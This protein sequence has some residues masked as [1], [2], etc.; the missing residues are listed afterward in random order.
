MCNFFYLGTDEDS[1]D[2][3]TIKTHFPKYE[4]SKISPFFITQEEEERIKDIERKQR[5]IDEAA[6]TKQD[7]KSEGLGALMK[8]NINNIIPDFK[9]DIKTI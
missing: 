3:R 7:N 5:M 4:V 8:D 9:A 2:R 6:N 1:L